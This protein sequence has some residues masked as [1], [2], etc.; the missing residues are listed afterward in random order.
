[1]ADEND[2][3]WGR[4]RA[5]CLGR[6]ALGLVKPELWTITTSRARP[7]GLRGLRTRAE[8][9]G[10]SLTVGAG[11]G[12]GWVLYVTPAVEAEMPR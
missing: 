7:H 2:F 12:G 11:P 6:L 3:E 4:F 1:M 9:A 8:A 10:G 5:R